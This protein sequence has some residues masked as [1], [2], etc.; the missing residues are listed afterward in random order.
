MPSLSSLHPK[1]F[2][3][4]A[5]GGLGSAF[6]DMLLAEGVEVWGTARDPLRFRARTGRSGFHPVVMDLADTA[7]TLDAWRRATGPA[8]GFA[9]L[10]NNAGYGHFGE[11]ATEPFAVWERQV[12]AM[13]TTT[14]ALTQAALTDMR[15][16]GRGTI[17]NVSSLAAEFPLPYMSAYNVAKA[18]L[19][20]FSES[21]MI[22]TAGTSLTVIDFR[23][24][25]Y[26]TGFNQAMP[27]RPPTTSDA[28]RLARAWQALETNLQ[29]APLPVRAAR[30][31]RRALAAP[32]SGVVRSGSFFQA[33]LA[34]FLARFVSLSWR[35]A[36]AARYLGVA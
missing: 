35:R 7:G 2:V 27:S 13:L 30:D 12:Q 8:G 3:T 25:D 29:K 26:R 33:R 10:I 17:V 20:A 6:V 28:P 11:F 21:L 1:A 14:M 24:G 31:L 23:P 16:R 19:S 18:G 36:V 9:L 5:S 22:E 15:T 34:P 4:G 32:R